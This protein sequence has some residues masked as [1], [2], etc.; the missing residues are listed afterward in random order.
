M[1]NIEKKLKK[2]S[3]YIKATAPR[4]AATVTK[5]KLE[6][7]LAA[8]LTCIGPEDSAEDS[9]GIVLLSDGEP[10]GTAAEEETGA[11]APGTP[12]PVGAS[13]GATSVGTPE[14]ST[15][16]AEVG[17]ATGEDGTAST[18]DCSADGTGAGAGAV[19]LLYGG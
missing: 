5:P 19:P 3:N 2:S 14:V 1:K 17:A 15:T 12:E 11:L 6:P 9:C 10:D 13:V 7:N 18:E 8:P 4:T 16:G